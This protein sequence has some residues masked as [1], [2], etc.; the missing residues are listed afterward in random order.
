[1]KQ[2]IKYDWLL[3]IA[4]LVFIELII[5]PVGEFPLNDDWA[6]S[7]TIYN[8]LNSGQLTFSF[9]QGFPDLPRFLVSLLFC[10]LFGFSFTLLRIITFVTL[11]F[12]VIVF[13]RNLKALHIHPPYRILLHGL[14]FFNPLTLLLSNTYLSDVF[15]LLLT[16]ISFQYMLLFFTTEKR[17]HYGLFIVFSLIATLNRQISL[18]IPFAFIPI[19]FYAI[20]KQKQKIA[21]SILPFAINCVGIFVYAFLAEQNALL[22]G[23]YHLQ[24]KRILTAISNPSLGAVS[25]THLSR[26]SKF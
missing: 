17:T 13:S 6:Y 23:N 3:V 16:L 10:K 8:Y 5:Q 12:A 2:I 20:E 19:Y 11:L 15:Q 1:M 9:W 21:L 18:V 14:L 25:Y 7:K 24:S 26:R 4:V 22:P